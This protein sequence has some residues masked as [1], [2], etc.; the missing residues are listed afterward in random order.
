MM[1]AVLETV[2]FGLPLVMDEAGNGV[3]VPTVSMDVIAVTPVRGTVL[4]S[5]ML[6]QRSIRMNNCARLPEQVKGG[7]GVLRITP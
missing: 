3:A 5:R 1:P 4:P 7:D 6:N 2:T